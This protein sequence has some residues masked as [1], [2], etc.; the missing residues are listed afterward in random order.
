MAYDFGDVILVKF[1][2]TNQT[3]SKQR[4]AI[5]DSCCSGLGHALP[6]SWH[7]KLRAVQIH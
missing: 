7:T 2:F 5:V 4:L 1:P 3:S 6:L